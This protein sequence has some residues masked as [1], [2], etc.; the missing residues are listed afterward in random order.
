MLTFRQFISQDGINESWKQAW[1]SHKRSLDIN[2]LG[3]PGGPKT[4][5]ERI[6]KRYGPK[7][8]SSAGIGAAIGSVGGPKMAAIGGAIGATAAAA[9]PIMSHVQSIIDF[10]KR[11]DERKLEKKYSMFFATHNHED[12]HNLLSQH[13]N[14]KP[15]EI[16][17]LKKHSDTAYRKNPIKNKKG[18]LLPRASNT[19]IAK[20]NEDMKN[21]LQKHTTPTDTVV[22]HGVA[23]AFR[24]LATISK[25]VPGMNKFTR[26]NKLSTSLDRSVAEDFAKDFGDRTVTH[27]HVLVLHVPKG[28]HAVYTGGLKDHYPIDD[29][30]KE[31][32]LGPGKYHIF[33]REKKGGVTYHYANYQSV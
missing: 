12:T 26:H 5:T 22:Y 8:A 3:K 33:H 30:E 15:E 19:E 32:V 9:S 24:P 23:R 14:Y 18:K 7:I 29:T 6:L 17:I 11:S 10:K 25:I 20:N 31:L 1:K 16:E 4:H 2:L 27:K 13:Y 28:S 21:I